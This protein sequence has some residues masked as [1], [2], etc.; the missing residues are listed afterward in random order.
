MSLKDIFT[1]KEVSQI[2]N[3][4]ATTITTRLSKCNFYLDE[5]IDYRKLGNRLPILFNQKGI[6]KIIGSY[7][8]KTKYKE[9]NLMEVKTLKQISEEYDIRPTTL[10]YRLNLE[11]YNLIEN[12]DYRELGNRQPIIFS[13]EGEKK[14]V[15]PFKDL[16]IKKD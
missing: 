9:V 10:I 5:N 11:A 8:P 7:D 4:P 3:I 14:I 16:N 13:K 6:D 15:T 12:I 1:L 2:Y